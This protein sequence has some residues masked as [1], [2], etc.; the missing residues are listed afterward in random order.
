VSHI[1]STRRGKTAAVLI[2]GA[3]LLGG[4]LTALA[5]PASAATAK[6]PVDLSAVTT[7]A[8]TVDRVG[9]LH[10][11]VTVASAPTSSVAA[12]AAVTFTVP[13]SGSVAASAA[14][15]TCD[16]PVAAPSVNGFTQACTTDSALAPG[17]S[18]AVGVDVTPVADPSIRSLSV[19][20]AVA[21]LDADKT[22]MTDPVSTNNHAKTLL[23]K[24]IDH[25]D[26]STSVV[27]D[28]PIDRTAIELGTATLT[29]DG[30]DPVFAK[31]TLVVGNGTENGFSSPPGL[32]CAASLP[33]SLNTG[34][35]RVCTTIDPLASGASLTV[36]F[37]IDPSATAKTLN[38][39]SNVAKVG[40]TVVDADLTNNKVLVPVTLLNHIAVG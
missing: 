22:T 34:F 16:A 40:A 13:H 20:A 32:S 3:T 21:L 11:T 10:A 2:A 37:A 8:K 5:A 4:T 36:S 12:R 15:L 29:N 26:I 38:I 35:R 1:N 9:T 17:G 19:N 18:L 23:V 39:T 31:L 24:I 30:T 27:A 14:G 7:G 25:A 28:G 33:N 6:S